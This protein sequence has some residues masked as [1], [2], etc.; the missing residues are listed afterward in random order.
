MEK[1]YTFSLTSSPAGIKKG[2]KKLTRY[3][4]ELIKVGKYVK[5]SVGLA[6][7]VTQ[8]T[9]V[10]WRDTFKCWIENGLKVPIPLGHAAA[11]DPEKNQ[12]WVREMF[13]EGDA[14]MGVLEL[15]DPK[16][17]LTTDVSIY[18]PCDFVDGHGNEYV[19]PITHVALCTN[20]VI[21]GLKGFEKLSLSL[22]DK[23]MDKQKLAKMLAPLAGLENEFLGKLY[24]ALASDD[25]GTK[26]ITALMPGLADD[27]DDAAIEAWIAKTKAAAAFSR[28]DP[29]SDVLVKLVAENRTIKIDGLVKAGLITPATKKAIEGQYTESKTLALTLATGAND[30]FD[31][32]MQILTENKTVALGEKS[33]QQLLELANQRAQGEQ[34]PIA[35]DVDKRV[36][37]AK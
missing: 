21:P 35:R 22:G 7:E 10:H 33:A 37:A 29:T 24:L 12:G 31:F 6:F 23:P 1:N 18:V 25:V 30:G 16:L 5:D 14:L 17:A 3:T 28:T 34:N 26:G 36:E 32:L 19:Q 11:D 9:L 13:I 20:P 2:S 8:D 4:K 27:A 15:T